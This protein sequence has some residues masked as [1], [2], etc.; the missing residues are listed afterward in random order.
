MAQVDVTELL[1]DPDFIDPMQVVT[2]VPSVNSFGE[3]ILTDSVLN[4]VGSVQPADG[5]ALSRIPEALR[6][7]DLKSFWFKGVIIATAPGKYSSIL[8][9]RGARFQVKNVFDWTNFGQ[10]WTEGLCVAEV[11]A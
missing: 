8:T 10:G 1:S 3:N 9:F 7:S 5:H 6:S 4:T 11:P 2:R